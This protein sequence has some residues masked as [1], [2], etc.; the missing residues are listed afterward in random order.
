ME[1]IPYQAHKPSFD[2]QSNIFL[3]KE[4]QVVKKWNTSAKSRVLIIED[5]FMW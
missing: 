3:K 2:N 1:K 4:I 5:E